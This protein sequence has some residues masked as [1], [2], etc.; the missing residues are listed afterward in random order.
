MALEKTL[1]TLK[2]DGLKDRAVTDYSYTFNVAVNADNLP[3][4]SP[5][6]GKL[7]VKVEAFVLEANSE[8]LQWM[9]TKRA[10]NGSLEIMVPSESDKLLKTIKFENAY[11]CDYKETW[12]DIVK[13]DIGEIT[14]PSANF[15]E[16]W[17][18]WEKFDLNGAQSVNKRA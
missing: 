6:G 10:K 7:Y 14:K 12:S 18:A 2:I 13:N 3:V 5:R 4:G 15:E 8:L 9:V 1:A 16:I 17:I 11:C